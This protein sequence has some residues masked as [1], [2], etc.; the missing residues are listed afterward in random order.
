M[1]A[2]QNGWMLLLQM[3]VIG[4]FCVEVLRKKE[5]MFRCSFPK[6]A[7]FQFLAPSFSKVEQA[8]RSSCSRCGVVLVWL[9]Q[10]LMA[11][12]VSCPLWMLFQWIAMFNV[13]RCLLPEQA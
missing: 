11:P 8:E 10:H 2:S 4:L 7:E 9:V 5:G 3:Q 6:R 13:S 12:G 1:D